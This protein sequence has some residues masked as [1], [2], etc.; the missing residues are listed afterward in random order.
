MLILGSSIVNHHLILRLKHK[1]NC[2]LGER[3]NRISETVD[4]LKLS[5]AKCLENITLELRGRVAH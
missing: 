5:Y 1:A 4:N 3:N 2:V